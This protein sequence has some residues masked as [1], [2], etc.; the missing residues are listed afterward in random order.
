MAGFVL[1]SRSP[2]RRELLASAGYFPE[3][4]P[5]DIDETPRPGESPERYV[6]RVAQEK[7]EACRRTE[8]VLAAD[9]TV[10]LDGRSIGKAESPDEAQR[11]LR[12]LS[13]RTHIVRTAVVLRVDR[14]LWDVVATA[15]TF[16]ELKD[17]D[18]ARYIETGEPFDKAGA[19]GIQGH[20]GALVER[21]EGSYTNVVG[22][23]LTETLRLL[24]LAELT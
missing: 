19:Y 14:L 17:A 18:I 5:V 6:V 10:I 23:P 24:R 20:G 12:E 13:G 16:R 8:P 9:T 3:V 21:V 22:L 4:V 15:V 7:V 2:R 1:A 11:W